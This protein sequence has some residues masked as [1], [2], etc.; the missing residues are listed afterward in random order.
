MWSGA[1]ECVCSCE[2][3]MASGGYQRYPGEK[4]LPGPYDLK[5]KLAVQQN[6][7]LVGK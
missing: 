4:L 2:Q 1:G 7:K 6:K 5:E 3:G